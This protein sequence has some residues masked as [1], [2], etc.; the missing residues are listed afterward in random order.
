MSGVTRGIDASEE[1]MSVELR[2]ATIE[3]SDEL[4][5]RRSPLRQVIWLIALGLLA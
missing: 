2:N 3:G 5:S 1:R 4:R